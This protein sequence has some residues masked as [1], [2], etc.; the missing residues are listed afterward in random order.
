MLNR[1]K[2]VDIAIMVKSSP[3]KVTILIVK[4]EL[5][6]PLVRI[7]LLWCFISD[8]AITVRRPKEGEGGCLTEENIMIKLKY[9][10]QMKKRTC[11][12]FLLIVI[13]LLFSSNLNIFGQNEK[14]KE[15]KQYPSRI[16]LKED[17]PI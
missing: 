13:V 15:I 2:K 14:K 5:I 3:F 8:V 1:Q 17:I 16:N 7:G 10:G 12:G 11:Y 9:R 4:K 6:P